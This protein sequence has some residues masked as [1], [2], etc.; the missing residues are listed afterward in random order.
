MFGTAARCAVRPLHVPRKWSRTKAEHNLLA[1]DPGTWIDA[2]LVEV[3]VPLAHPVAS[4]NHIS[5]ECYYQIPGQKIYQ[6]YPIYAP[7]KEPCGSLD[8]RRRL[9][10]TLPG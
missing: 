5:A 9:F 8:W 4:P 3:E 1:D 7:G 10:L 2:E 6:S